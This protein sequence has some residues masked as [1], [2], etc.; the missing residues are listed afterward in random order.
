LAIARPG[1]PS[2]ASG[3]LGRRTAWRQQSNSSG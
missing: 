1:H 2:Q 3:Q